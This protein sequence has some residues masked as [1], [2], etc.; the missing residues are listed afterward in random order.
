[1]GVSW[2]VTAPLNKLAVIEGY[3]EFGLIFWQ[4]MICVVILGLVVC[5]R[6][7]RLP[8]GWVHVKIYIIIAIFGTVLPNTAS[9]TA[10]VH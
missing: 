1:M 7:Q 8:F 3:Q 2:G 5:L 9:Y 6:R 4:Q 10:A